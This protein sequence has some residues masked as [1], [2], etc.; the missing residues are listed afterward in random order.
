MYL[1]YSICL[2]FLS[3]NDNKL[4]LEIDLKNEYFQQKMIEEKNSLLRTISLL[5]VFCTIMV[6]IAFQFLN[7]YVYYPGVERKKKFEG[8]ALLCTI[9]YVLGVIPINGGFAFGLLLVALLLLIAYK[10]FEH[11]LFELSFKQNIPKNIHK[12]IPNELKKLMLRQQELWIFINQ[13]NTKLS[14]PFFVLY[15]SVM[16]IISFYFYTYLFA[17]V[18]DSMRLVSLLESIVFT[19][20]FTILGC[21]LS[22]FAFSMQNGFQDIRQLADCSL[23]LEQKLKMANGEYV[24]FHFFRTFK[25]KE[26]NEIEQKL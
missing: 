18:N 10:E 17:D 16:W 11:V 4:D 3:K 12:N 2:T 7:V 21:L 5:T 22:C 23:K 14:Y 13:F 26:G 6:I 25:V 8:E 9:L 20:V 19:F 1:T 24:A 15:F